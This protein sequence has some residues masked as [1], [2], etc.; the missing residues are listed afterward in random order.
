MESTT[1]GPAFVEPTEGDKEALRIR[2]Q[3]KL[4]MEQA[5]AEDADI[6]LR[7]KKIRRLMQDKRL[8]EMEKALT[9]DASANQADKQVEVLREEMKELQRQA[10]ADR[11]TA[12]ERADKDR[13]AADDRLEKLLA[14]IGEPKSEAKPIA[15]IISAMQ[16]NFQNFMNS[17]IP[18]ITKKDD[19]GKT[20]ESLIGLQ[21]A[22]ATMMS[23]LATAL[24]GKGD[25]GKET[26]DMVL[27]MQ[28]NTSQMMTGLVTAMAPKESAA[29]NEASQLYKTAIELTLKGANRDNAQQ[30]QLLNTVLTAALN[31]KG[32]TLKP[33]DMISLIGD[34]ESRSETATG[35]RWE[36]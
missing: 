27:Q 3:T 35:S 23:N 32:D 14:K 19:G 26:R 16:T 6:Q 30:T 31:P 18:I 8:N 33:Q 24:A 20:N 21:N 17:L 9:T 12:D 25:S 1:E 15:D 13:R 28:N 5:R 4:A 10:E 36:G 34:I 29:M 11:K 7:E 2:E 22:N